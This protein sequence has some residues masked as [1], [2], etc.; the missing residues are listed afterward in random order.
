M[1]N[2]APLT[3]TVQIRNI[4]NRPGQPTV[5]VQVSRAQQVQLEIGLSELGQFVKEAVA[6]AEFIE[7]QVG[8]VP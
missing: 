1:P 2:G 8:P 4:V 7:Q 5:I 3:F 6:S